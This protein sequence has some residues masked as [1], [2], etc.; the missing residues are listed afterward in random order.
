MSNLSSLCQRL[1]ETEPYRTALH[2]EL[3]SAR[4]EAAAASGRQHC[5]ERLGLSDTLL[6]CPLHAHRF[7]LLSSIEREC[8]E[9]TRAD[10]T[11]AGMFLTGY[12]RCREVVQHAF[13]HAGK[14]QNVVFCAAMYRMISSL[15]SAFREAVEAAYE[16]V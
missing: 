16:S 5:P 13:D 15:Q 1:T 12:Q 2:A 14:A 6:H 3:L 4:D 9:A 7:P 11:D 8:L 10:M